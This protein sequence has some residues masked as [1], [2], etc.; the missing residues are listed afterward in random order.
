MTVRIETGHRSGSAGTPTQDRIVVLDDAVI[1]LDGASS[2]VPEERDGG[3]YADQLAAELARCL[4]RPDDLPLTAHLADAIR[5]VVARTQLMPGDAPSST[6]LICR[7]TEETIEV[8]TLGDSTAIVYTR[9]QRAHR[10]YD[11]RLDPIA[12]S[13]RAAL[14]ARCPTGDE[15][16]RLMIELQA[17]QRALRNRP[18]G[19][20]IAEAD[21]AAAHEAVVRSWPRA[22]VD[23]VLLMT[24]GVADVVD[25]YAVNG[26]PHWYGI[27]ELVAAEGVQAL[28]DH[29]HGV[30]ETDSD[31]SRWPRSKVHDDKAAALI[32]ISELDHRLQPP[33][34]ILAAADRARERGD[35]AAAVDLFAS[36][37]GARFPEVVDDLDGTLHQA[38]Y[39]YLDALARAGRLDELAALA[40]NDARARRR[41][42]R[43]LHEEGRA[44]DLRARAA[45]GDR[46]ALY[47]LIRLL[48][49]RGEQDAARQAVDDIAPDDEYARRLAVGA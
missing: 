14:Q 10:V 21:P 37:T 1:V 7:W 47:L 3:W 13:Q 43:Q 36:V 38:Y 12:A 48:R 5:A 49:A 4:R 8:L 35:Y 2:W 32:K 44:D 30:E 9:D 11:D 41:L 34:S 23:A 31:R 20:W 39:G 46:T 42:D 19:Y 15:L 40:T 16:T 33:F 25:R 26:F 22:E 27:F 17:A 29:V 28:A 24:D 45:S 18:G 6:V